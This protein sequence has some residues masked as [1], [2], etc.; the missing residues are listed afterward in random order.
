MLIF[1]H[2]EELQEYLSKIRLTMSIGFVPT[3]GALHQGHAS[4]IS[5]VK[6]HAENVGASIFVNPTQFL[7]NEDFST[8]PRTLDQDIELLNRMKCDWVFIPSN[9]EMYPGTTELKVDIGYLGTIFEGAFRPYH[10]QG[11]A[12]VVLKLLTIVQPSTVVFGR[13]DAQQCAIISTLIKSLHLPTR[14]LM[15]ETVRETDGLALSSRNRYLSEQERINAVGLYHSLRRGCLKYA[16]TQNRLESV[17][18]MYSKIKEYHP[19]SID[20]FAIVNPDS[21]LPPTTSESAIAIGAVR[22]GNTRLIDNIK[23]NEF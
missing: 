16:E 15:G 23:V 18:T 22:F 7:P 8:Y 10:F 19:T 5:H 2:V 6:N 20:Y 4:L 3:M 12:T 14:I 17:D 13:K 1:K 9:S 21:F 11:V